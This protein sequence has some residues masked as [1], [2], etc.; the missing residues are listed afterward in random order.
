MFYLLYEFYSDLLIDRLYK[1]REYKFDKHTVFAPC[2]YGYDVLDTSCGRMPSDSNY[3]WRVLN[4]CVRVGGGLASLCLW[5]IF[6]IPGIWRVFRPYESVY[7]LLG[8]SEWKIVFRKD[9]IWRDVH[10]F[11]CVYVEWMMSMCSFF[12][13]MDSNI[14]FYQIVIC[15]QNYFLLLL[16]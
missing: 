11:L 7:V 16:S 14:I 8:P 4:Q 1:K 13:R 3:K 10:R 5:N 12:Y 6:H 2:G 9:D 15:Y